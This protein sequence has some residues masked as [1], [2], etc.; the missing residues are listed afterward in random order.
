[1]RLEELLRE[2]DKVLMNPNRLLIASLLFLF[3]PKKE[4]EIVRALGMPWG[5]FSTHIKHLEREGYVVRRRVF[6]RRGYRTFV[7]L[8]PL[9]RERYRRLVEV[10]RA[11]LEQVDGA[12]CGRKAK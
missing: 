8:T 6:T 5:V 9:G 4:S 7:R 11:L 10:L 3:G 1:M 12:G 2:L